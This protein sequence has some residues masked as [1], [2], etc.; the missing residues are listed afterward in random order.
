VSCIELNLD[1]VL[2]LLAKAI[3]DSN[4]VVSQGRLRYELKKFGIAKRRARYN[5]RFRGH[6]G[7]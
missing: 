2:G 3:A 1:L 7:W 4:V 5:G 6:D